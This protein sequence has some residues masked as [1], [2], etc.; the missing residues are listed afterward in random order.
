MT[1]SFVRFTWGWIARIFLI[2]AL[3]AGAQ[4]CSKQICP[5]FAGMTIASHATTPAKACG[6]RNI[7]L[8]DTD[9]YFHIFQNVTIFCLK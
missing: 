3:R 5:A 6:Y 4:I 9:G 8:E 2:L 1:S 7:R